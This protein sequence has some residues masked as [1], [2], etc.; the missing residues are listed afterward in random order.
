MKRG[1]T[2]CR[3]WQIKTPKIDK[4]SAEGVRLESFYYQRVFVK[5]FCNIACSKLS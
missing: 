2:P 4:F 3:G 5:Q 1:F